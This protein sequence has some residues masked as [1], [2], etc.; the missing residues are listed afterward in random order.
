M[1]KSLFKNAI[2]KFLLSLFNIIVPILANSYVFKL[3]N[4]EQVG[5][6]TF[7]QT[8]YGYFLIFAG[9]GVYQYGL[10]EIS[11]V[12][13]NKEKLSKV[14]TSLFTITI[15]SNIVVTI[16]YLLFINTF[17]QGDSSTYVACLILTFSLFSN[18]FYTEWV[19]EALESYDFITIKTIIIK[20]FY[21]ILLFIFVK[22]VN[23]FKEYLIL[24]SLSTILNNIISYI[25]V[26]REIKFNFKDI[27]ISP[28][29]KPMLLVVILSNANVLYTQFDRLILGKISEVELAYYGVAQ[30]VSSMVN[31]MLLTVV[32]VTIPRLSNYLSTKKHKEY[33]KLL[34]K[35]SD[36]YF[37]L[38]FP[39][40][41]GMAL[42]SKEIILLYT[43]PD[44]MPAVSMLMLFCIYA[45]IVGYEII[46]SNQIMY[47]HG[48]EKQQV[49]VIFIGGF[50][51]LI[52]N[53]TLLKLNILDGNTAIIT[54]LIAE[55]VVVIILKSYI[56]KHLNINFSLFSIDKLKYLYISLIFIPIILVIKTYITGNLIICLIS[57]PICALVYFILLLIIKDSLI[58]EFLDKALTILKLKKNK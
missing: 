21:V 20:I 14:F 9:F 6:I 4:K 39:T 18:I 1:N 40:C 29:L 19:N 24:L 41:I 58:Y 42:L 33:L 46:L 7:S 11:R 31:T 47:L 3:L 12:R 34:K 50:I 36:I 30:N 28:Y 13:D 10:R 57:I 8:I 2:F 48:K 43:K 37:L 56:V 26:K 16:L 35:I 23:N 49:K 55:G 54:T 27:L 5:A 51:N 45:V 32:Y 17:I 22:S 38:L 53:F 25:Y 44:Y 52:L 15:I